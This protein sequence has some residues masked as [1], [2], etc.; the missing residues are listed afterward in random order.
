MTFIKDYRFW[1][2]AP[3][4]AVAAPLLV[5]LPAVGI[6]ICIGFTVYEMWQGYRKKDHGY[7]D[8]LGGLGGLVVVGCLLFILHITEVYS[9]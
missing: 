2:H 7:R 9:G 6:A 5:A 1:M 4:G 8:F 3:V